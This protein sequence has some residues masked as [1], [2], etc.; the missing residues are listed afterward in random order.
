MKR[1][2]QT[3]LLTDY[4]E[5]FSHLG[6][7]KIYVGEKPM[8]EEIKELTEQK[9]I[10]VPM[11]F[12]FECGD[13]WYWLIDQLMKCIHNYCEWNHKEFIHITQVKEK[14]GTLSFYYTGGNEM[15]H[16]MV[17]FAESLSANICETCGT[18]ENV[19]RT[20]GWIYTACQSCYEGNGRARDLKW[21]K[22]D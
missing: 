2:L 14:F 10:V 11:Q 18:T 16:G 17:W 4:P 8:M 7:K 19:G 12:G 9:E 5:F 6:D 13:G 15:I 21:T 22:N 20:V 1:E 3:K